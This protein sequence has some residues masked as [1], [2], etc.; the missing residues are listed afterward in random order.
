MNLINIS[1]PDMEARLYY[2]YASILVTCCSI[3]SGNSFILGDI[4]S[5]KIII[6]LIN[7]LVLISHFTKFISTVER[8]DHALQEVQSVP[9]M[10]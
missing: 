2:P 8:S 1:H 5:G 4:V 6:Y 10:V 9:C 7:R 3:I